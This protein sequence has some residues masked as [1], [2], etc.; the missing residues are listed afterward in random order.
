ME[1]NLDKALLDKIKQYY[2]STDDNIVSVGFGFKNRNGSYTQ[3]KTLVFTVR[4]KINKESGLINGSKLIPPFIKINE[5]LTLK[6]DV[7][8]GSYSVMTSLNG[9]VEDDLNPPTNRNKIRPIKGGLSISNYNVLSDS[10]GTMGFIAVDRTNDSLVG[11]TNAHVIVDDQFLASDRNQLFKGSNVLSHDIVQP[12][13]FNNSS[14]ENSIG[15]VKRYL[16][17]TDNGY[18]YADV[19][20]LTVKKQDLDESISIMQEGLNYDFWLPF[21]STEEIN[22]LLTA[23]PDLYFSGRA[24]GARGEGDIKLKVS[25]LGVVAYLDLDLQDTSATVD[26]ADCIKFYAVDS[27]N[28]NQQIN[29]PVNIGDSGSALV[30]EIDGIR[31]II[32]IVF[33]AQYN[34]TTG[35]II[36]GLAK[37]IIQTSLT[38]CGCNPSS[39]S[40][41]VKANGLRASG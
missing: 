34:E 29:C 25:E 27:S 13:E 24:S 35:E 10:A 37:P 28:N 30:A 21:A 2:E 38:R 18:N 17:V 31:K 12:N 33:A 8:Q 40:K 3:E 4:K 20:L 14:L 36:S 23:N 6:T 41:S 5:E 9:C 22:S 1:P 15:I 11:V 7:I 19:A 16:P 39:S 26:F 32:G